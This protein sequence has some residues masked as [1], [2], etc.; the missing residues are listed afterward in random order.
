MKHRSGNKRYLHLQCLMMILQTRI[1]TRVD[2]FLL[3]RYLWNI[4]FTLD[5]WKMSNWSWLIVPSW[6]WKESS[7]CMSATKTVWD[8]P[9]HTL[10]PNPPQARRAGCREDE[11]TGPAAPR[12]RVRPEGSNH[13][14]TRN[15]SG[16]SAF[17]TAFD[18]I[19]VCIGRGGG[20]ERNANEMGGPSAPLISHLY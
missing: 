13:S 10:V 9:V 6:T 3:K 11:E 18:L 15:D 1:W 19:Q 5:L 7:R 14:A 4:N 16:D 12:C 2:E 17:R 8:S 20:E